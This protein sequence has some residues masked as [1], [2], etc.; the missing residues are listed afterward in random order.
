MTAR[1]AAALETREALLDAGLEVAQEHG[2]SGMSVNRVVAAAGVAKG[3]FYVHF[4]D[5][6][7]FVN[8]LHQRYTEQSAAAVVAVMRGHAPGWRRLRQMIEAYFE[9]SLRYRGVKAL[10]LEAR[11]TPG[12]A[13]KVDARNAAFVGVAEPDLKAMGWADPNPA[14]RL[15]VA[16]AGELMMAEMTAGARDE[17][18]RAALWTTLE[19][20]DLG[21]TDLPDSETGS[22]TASETGSEA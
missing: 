15:V 8:A 1:A 12:V 22:E 2:L 14:A 13:A 11:N 10:A 7:A 19:R 9:S 3:T 21:R 16:M 20:M 4:A 6:D 17:A 18:G 5:R